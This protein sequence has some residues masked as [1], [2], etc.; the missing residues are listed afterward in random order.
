MRIIPNSEATQFKPGQSGNPSGRPRT[1]ALSQ[2]LRQKLAERVEGDAL[3][4]TVAQKLADNLIDK[5]MA[6]DP[7]VFRAIVDRVEGR[8][9]QQLQI[10]NVTVEHMLGSDLLQMNRGE[11][12]RY[13]ETGE[14]PPWFDGGQREPDDE[15]ETNG[16]PR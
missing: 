13:A 12:R 2:A 11:M 10:A 6:G 16:E 5:A 15:R 8:P 3:G 7:D 14:L 9:T 1:A 4:R